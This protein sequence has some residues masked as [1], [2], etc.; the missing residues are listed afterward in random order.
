MQTSHPL[1]NQA[2]YS[3]HMQITQK[4]TPFLSYPSQAREAAE[5][6][7]SLLPD[8]KI[9]H[10]HTN[11]LDGSELLVDFQLSGVQFLA[12]NTGQSGPAWDFTHSFS[13]SV[14]CETQ[15][16]IDRLW[17]ALSEGGAEIQC[18]WL[19]DK[20]GLCWQ[21]VPANFGAMMGHPDREKAGRM[22][23]ALMTMV[24]P[25]M[26]ALNAAFEGD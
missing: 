12:L 10:L 2:L 25:D 15:A 7:C 21:I 9:N 16:E 18:C 20:F 6:Y 17:A 3:P 23:Q 19:K 22:F 8:S 14:A 1:P 24:K 5:F 26:A 13:I 11:P 4:V